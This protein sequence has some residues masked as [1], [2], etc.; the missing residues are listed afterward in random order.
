MTAILNSPAQHPGPGQYDHRDQLCRG[1]PG[2]LCQ[3]DQRFKPIDNRVPGPGAYTVRVVCIQVFSILSGGS[4]RSRN[5]TCDVM[6]SV[7]IVYTM[8]TVEPDSGHSEERTTPYNGQTA[9]PLPTTVCML[10]PPKKGHPPNNVQNTRPQRVH[11]LEV[12]LY[13]TMK[14]YCYFTPVIAVENDYVKDFGFTVVNAL[15]SCLPE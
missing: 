1:K 4:H 9:W 13:I 10:E 2:L 14:R 7:L 15:T 3:R 8:Y 11:C 5:I 6:G 12:P